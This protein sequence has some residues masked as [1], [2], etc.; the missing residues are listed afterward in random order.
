LLLARRAGAVALAQGAIKRGM[1]P[2]SQLDTPWALAL[3]EAEE[4]A[5]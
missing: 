2:A 4:R 5:G 1:R 3:D